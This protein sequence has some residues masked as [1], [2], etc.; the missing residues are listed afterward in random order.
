MHILTSPYFK[1]RT[2]QTFV[3]LI[4]LLYFLDCAESLRLFGRPST[5][6]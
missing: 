4:M 2:P 1:L 6:K 5:Y 3:K